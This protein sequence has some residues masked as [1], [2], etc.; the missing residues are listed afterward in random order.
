MAWCTDNR[1]EFSSLRRAKFSTMCMV[2]N[3]LS[4]Q[5]NDRKDSEKTK[6]EQC[7]ESLEHAS[8]CNDPNCKY[9]SCEKMKSILQHAKECKK[10]SQGTCNTCHKV[11]AIICSHAKRCTVSKCAVPFCLVIRLKRSEQMVSLKLRYQLLQRRVT[12]TINRKT[13]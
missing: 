5:L 12:A 6:V 3:L 4:N 11:V 2:S 1:Y 13:H 9:N 8:A 10:R 7:I